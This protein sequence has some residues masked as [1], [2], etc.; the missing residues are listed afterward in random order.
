M[1]D[2]NIY[3]ERLH[4]LR[5]DCDKHDGDGGR[6][7]VV[8]GRHERWRRLGGIGILRHEHDATYVPWYLPP[9]RVR[10]H[11]PGACVC[12]SIWCMHHDRAVLRVAVHVRGRCGAAAVVVSR[13]ATAWL[14]DVDG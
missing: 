6:S 10:L 1:V 4:G 2:D 5:L 9:G 3:D 7:V 11:E 12:E 14:L 8:R 13:F